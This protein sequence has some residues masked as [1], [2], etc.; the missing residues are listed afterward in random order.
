MRS[1]YPSL[2]RF[3]PARKRLES[4]G[5]RYGMCWQDIESCR[6][7]GELCWLA[8]IREKLVQLV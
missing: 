1:K 6:E 8:R 4:L 7:S 2:A 5:D 3:L